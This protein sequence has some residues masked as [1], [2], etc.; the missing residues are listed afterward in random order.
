MILRMHSNISGTAAPTV[1]QTLRP[2]GTLQRIWQTK[3]RRTWPPP[4]Q[5]RFGCH[6]M[7]NFRRHPLGER[8]RRTMS[9]NK[10]TQ[11]PTHTKKRTPNSPQSRSA[12]QNNGL[13]SEVKA[14]TRKRPTLKRHTQCDDYTKQP[15]DSEEQKEAQNQ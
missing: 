6:R 8:T 1:H 14:H 9:E 13:Q 2:I 12:L 11:Q 15:L 10:S 3:A 5:Y 7:N 4:G